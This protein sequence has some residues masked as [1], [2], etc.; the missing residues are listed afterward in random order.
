MKDSK[1]MANHLANAMYQMMAKA[2]EDNKK[3]IVA[4]V[5]D[6]NFIAEVDPDEV[7]ENKEEVLWKK[8]KNKIGVNKLKSFIKERKK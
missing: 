8:K 2:I 4:D 5:L 1:K 7:P 6:D 3:D